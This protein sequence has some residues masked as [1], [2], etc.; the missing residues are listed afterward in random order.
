MK[1]NSILRYNEFFFGRIVKRGALVCDAG[2][3]SIYG[4][5]SAWCHNSVKPNVKN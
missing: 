5:V 4:V 3:A 2:A 1:G